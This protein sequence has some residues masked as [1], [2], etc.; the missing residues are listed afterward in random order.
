MVSVDCI[1]KLIIH[2]CKNYNNRIRGNGFEKEKEGH[3]KNKKKNKIHWVLFLTWYWNHR[4][5]C[6]LIL[7]SKPENYDPGN[8]NTTAVGVYWVS[9]VK[10]MLLSEHRLAFQ[11][12]VS[13]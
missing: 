4:W 11:Q 7:Q 10:G 5:K 9:K 13:I 6:L 3:G 1:Y 2:I 8:V 12:W